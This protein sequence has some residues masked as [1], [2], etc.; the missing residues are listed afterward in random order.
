MIVILCIKAF[1]SLT[2]NPIQRIEKVWKLNFYVSCFSMLLIVGCGVTKENLISSENIS[3]TEEII[4]EY[5]VTCF[6]LNSV[7][8]DRGFMIDAIS[9]IV[10]PEIR[11]S[12][13]E[14]N[15]YEGIY[16][17]KYLNYSRLG[18]AE[19][20]NK[21]KDSIEVIIL[22]YPQEVASPN[23][24]SGTYLE[25]T[26][27]FGQCSVIVVEHNRSLHSIFQFGI[28]KGQYE[29]PDFDLINLYFLNIN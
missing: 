8:R 14:F 16:R 20:I 3:Y 23:Y 22:E 17:E 29:I 13:Y 10:N 26:G 28:L 4:L 11:I 12:L 7:H 21:V 18:G 15:G 24:K 5:Q 19:I 9:K 6:D 27:T 2:S 1:F 25:N